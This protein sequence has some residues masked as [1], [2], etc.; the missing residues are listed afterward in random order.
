MGGVAFTNTEKEQYVTY[1][2]F[3]NMTYDM[4]YEKRSTSNTKYKL[5]EAE[6][7]N[8]V[9]NAVNKYYIPGTGGW[10]CE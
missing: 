2:V 6:I 8:A 3:S 1:E 7:Q 9:A 10:N 5:H 4:C